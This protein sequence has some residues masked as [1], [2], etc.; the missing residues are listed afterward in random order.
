MAC[1]TFHDPATGARGILCLRGVR[2]KYCACGAVATLLCDG[3]VPGARG[4][5]R[6]C[7]R[8]ICEGCAT[9]V[10]VERDLCPDCRAAAAPRD[11]PFDA[12]VAYT[13]GSGTVAHLPC[14]GG[15]V[16]FDDGRVVAEASRHFGLGTNN[17]AELAAVG[18]ALAMT[19]DSGRAL[20]VRTDSMYV[21]GALTGDAPHPLAANVG[22][23]VELRRMIRGR[24]VAFEHVPGHRGVW[25][26]ERADELANRGRLNPHPRPRR[27]S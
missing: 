9:P 19:A 15:V 17:V 8:A 12:L 20:V 25:G 13:D 7:N 23:I 4:R 26:N 14:G 21:I 18:V 27:P 11:V 16:L 22:L 6:R 5:S 10:D 1:V 2:M 3:R 24:D